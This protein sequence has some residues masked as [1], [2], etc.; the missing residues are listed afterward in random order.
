VGL[1]SDRSVR[2]LK[3]PGRPFYPAADRAKILAALEAVSYVIIFNE[4]R[5]ERIIRRVKPDVLVKGEDY[6]GKTVDG[7]E[8]VTSYGGRVVLAPIL[9]GRSTTGTLGQMRT[10]IPSDSQERSRRRRPARAKA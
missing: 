2:A 4:T 6:S 9:A 7:G 8:F 1:N 3:G 10:A 5:A